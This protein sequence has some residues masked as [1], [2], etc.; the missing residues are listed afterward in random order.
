V[1][2]FAI[3]LRRER[4]EIAADTAV[5]V[6]TTAGDQKAIGRTSKIYPVPHLRCLVFGRGFL[7]VIAE[8]AFVLGTAPGLETAEDAAAAMPQVL[9]AA[10]ARLPIDSSQYMIA[11]VQLIGWS[12]ERRG[13]RWW[14]WASDDDFAGQAY[15]DAVFGV[16]AIPPVLDGLPRRHGTVAAHLVAVLQAQRRF[17][18]ARPDLGFFEIGGDLQL[19]TLTPDALRM[20]VVHRMPVGIDK[21]LARRLAAGLDQ[22]DP[23]AGIPRSSEMVTFE[24]AP[25]RSTS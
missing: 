22:L 9:R 8:A 21:Q 14:T 15:S 7:Q 2:A 19:W 11:E 5:F 17:Y 23:L 16:H 13:F 4:V 18:A 24:G 20:R 6:P 12:A 3:D 1:T 10:A 25:C